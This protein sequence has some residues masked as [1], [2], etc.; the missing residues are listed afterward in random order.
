MRADNLRNVSSIKNL[1]PDYRNNI[2]EYVITA[3]D[4][5]IFTLELT[6]TSHTSVSDKTLYSYFTSLD[7]FF[8]NLGKEYGG[9]LGVWTHIVKKK[10]HFDKDYQFESP[11]VQNLV[12]TYLTTF[13]ND[14]NNFYNTH[15][16]ITF[17]LK[18]SDINDG[19]AKCDA[20]AEL[21]STMIRRYN[22]T[23]LKVVDI[24][25]SVSLCKNNEFLSYLLNLNEVQLPLNDEEV[26][27]S[28]CDSD[29]FF[30]YDFF[31][32]RSKS[33]TK[34]K[35][36]T[37]YLLKGY[38][39]E[40]RAG[41]WDF[42]LE[43]PYE[44]ILS[45]SFIFTTSQ[46]TIN[47]IDRQINRLDSAGDNAV[48]ELEELEM[49]QAF[50]STGEIT[51]GDYQA[52][53]LIFGNTA[54]EAV[55]N[56]SR[57][58][59]AFTDKGLGARWSRATLDAMFAFLSVMPA[60]KYR[61]VNSAR[62]STSLACGFSLHNF[63]SG[64]AEYNPLGDGSAIMPI[65]TPTQG[66]YYMN[67]HY[68]ELDKN[69]I[70]QMIAGHFLMLGAT[71]T[72]KTTFEAM[73]VAFLQR[74]N[75]Q[76]FVVDYKRSTELYVRAYGGTY[77]TLESGVPTGLNPFQ[78]EENASPALLQFLYQFVASCAKDYRGL[79][80]DM[81]YL[82]IKNAV[83]AVMLL[84]LEQ[85]RFSLVLQ[86]IP[87]SSE[88]YARLARWCYFTDGD[89]A[90]TVDSPKNLFNPYEFDKIGFD[91]SVILETK[92]HPATEPILAI[93]LFYKNL[94]K[95][96]GRRL[97]TIVEE[98]YM[99]CNYPT[100]Q[101]MIKQTLKTGRLTGEFIGLVSQSPADAIQCEIFPAI[102]EQTPTKI[103][104]PNPEAVYDDEMIGY[105]R[106]G[107]TEKDFAILSS[108]DKESRKMLVKQGIYSTLLHF[109]LSHC[110]EFFPIISGTTEGQIEC[111]KIRQI[112]GDNPNNWIEPFLE[113]MKQKRFEQA[114]GKP[115]ES[116]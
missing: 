75:P 45:Q 38:P 18:Y 30:N 15:Y 16:Y 28:I 87:T 78:L 5:M 10:A 115:T 9:N 46:K 79:V 24:N 96:S 12:D 76:L 103:M 64:K 98:F 77:F 62:P 63:F 41:M 112:Y 52:A 69:V 1:L 58:I 57:A 3:Q 26:I 95:K 31:E 21:S 116:I 39:A 6:G 89:L 74:F 106:V 22:G 93:L 59:S 68:S 84:P 81:E 102:V 101:N 51:F 97:L 27:D 17:V 60:S 92:D 83:D 91:T 32:V 108:L 42:L 73:F 2:N 105:K 90:W 80:S 43:L 114:N 19:L 85:R 54:K 20:I 72:G 109:D 66:L 82:N 67:T 88:L 61:P 107:L 53:M 50:L 29:W 100:T 37:A 65:K 70:G 25:E 99:P 35:Y 44:F 111:E 11:F 48:R 110:S 94:M 49:A 7:D 34:S 14:N 36:G 104:L 86:S 23:I 71:G 40:T 13:K 8:L 113:R 47:Q 33:S 4:K 56:G 55:Q